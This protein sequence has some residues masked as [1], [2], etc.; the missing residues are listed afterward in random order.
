MGD[1]GEM[2]SIQLEMLDEM[3]ST[4][5]NC[6]HEGSEVCVPPERRPRCWDAAVPRQFNFFVGAVCLRAFR[7]VP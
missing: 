2:R 4:N 1:P 7:G 3:T 5:K 6:V